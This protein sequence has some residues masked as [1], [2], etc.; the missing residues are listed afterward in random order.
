MKS[1]DKDVPVVTAETITDEQIR[2]ITNLIVINDDLGDYATFAELARF[3]L[4]GRPSARRM[5]AEILNARQAMT[6]EG[7][8]S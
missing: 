6:S 2:S 5:C 1:N 8:E 7:G 3:A 4:A